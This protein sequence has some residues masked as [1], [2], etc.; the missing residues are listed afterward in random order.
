MRAAA[1]VVREKRALL[2]PLAFV[3]LANLAVYLL[4]VAPLRARVAS[5]QLESGRAR[6]DVQVAARQLEDAQKT[7]TGKARAADQL[8]AFYEDVLPGDLGAARRV[9]HLDLATLAREANLRVQRRTQAQEQDKD[10]TLV[11]LDTEM[12]LE[13]S[14][15]D[16]REF[17]YEIEKSDEFVV[18]NGVTLVQRDQDSGDL[19]LT[20]SLSTYFRADRGR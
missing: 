17:L 9:T 2:V 6:D 12:V 3:A 13:G 4:G 20:M 18:I 1:R 16:L 5:A 7:V 19:V 11:R 14:Y 15:G 8:R 10:S